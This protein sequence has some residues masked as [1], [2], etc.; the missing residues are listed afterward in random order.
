MKFK[1]TQEEYEELL[2]YLMDN[3]WYWTDIRY[4]GLDC[5]STEEV[6]MVGNTKIWSKIDE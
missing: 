1:L 4:E 3:G 2:Q 6:C 5:S